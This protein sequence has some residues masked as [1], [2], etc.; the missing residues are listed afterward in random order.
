MRIHLPCQPDNMKPANFVDL[1]GNIH[2][3]IGTLSQQLALA[4]TPPPKPWEWHHQKRLLITLESLGSDLAAIVNP[5]LQKGG[6]R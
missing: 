3:P 1:Q 5:Y 2:P 4:K 6:E